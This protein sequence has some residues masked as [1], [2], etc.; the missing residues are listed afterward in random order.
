MKR[1]F[2][3]DIGGV[4]APSINPSRELPYTFEE[5]KKLTPHPDAFEVLGRLTTE[6]FQPRNM[7]I[8][9]YCDEEIERNSRKWLEYHGF[10]EITKIPVSHLFYCRD[11]SHKNI[12][13]QELGITDFI[14]DR[15]KIL[16]SLE[17][18]PNRYL[19]D[20]NNKRE[21]AS[22]PEIKVVHSFTELA[23]QYL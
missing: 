21:T 13:C 20:I 5:L 23:D 14:D 22:I 15:E 17:T 9:S 16:L 3:S 7:F 12:I 8:V 19:F 4:L 2:G 18:V 1:I 11:R 10:H 6:I